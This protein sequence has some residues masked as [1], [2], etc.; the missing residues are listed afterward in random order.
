MAKSI[1]SKIKQASSFKE[2]C[3]VLP[4]MESTCKKIGID[5]ERVVLNGGNYYCER[6]SLELGIPYKTV[7][8]IVWKM[9]GLEK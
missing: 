6:I 5:P 4:Q 7:K 2:G 1:T 8:P 9:W 3:T